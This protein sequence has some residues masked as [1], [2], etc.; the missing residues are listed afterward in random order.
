[1]ISRTVLKL[2]RK[3]VKI[4]PITITKYHDERRTLFIKMYSSIL[5]A[6]AVKPLLRQQLVL[7][8]C[9]YQAIEISFLANQCTY[10]L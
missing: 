6:Q 5:F 1:M 7:V 8:L 9:F 4:F 10:F 3:T 2:D